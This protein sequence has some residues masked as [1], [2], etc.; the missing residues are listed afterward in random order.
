MVLPASYLNTKISGLRIFIIA[1]FLLFLLIIFYAH[2]KGWSVIIE[3][4][5]VDTQCDPAGSCTQ[6]VYLN[7]YGHR[8]EITN[9]L[10]LHSG[11]I[12]RVNFSCSWKGCRPDS[13]ILLKSVQTVK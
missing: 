2:Y 4:K 10:A 8:L 3:L 9:D 12:V 1:V 11:D 7:D 13:W 6:S 5:R